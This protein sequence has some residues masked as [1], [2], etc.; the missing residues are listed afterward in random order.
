MWINLSTK[1]EIIEIRK[2]EAGNCEECLYQDFISRHDKAICYLG[3]RLLREMADKVRS[4][5]H[6]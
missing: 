3:T 4:Q 5:F 6:R 1:H 2:R